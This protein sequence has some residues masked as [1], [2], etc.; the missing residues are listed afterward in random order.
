MKLAHWLGLVGLAFFLGLIAVLMQRR[1]LDFQN[2]DEAAAKAK[3]VGFFVMSDR[4]D[5]IIE[6]GFLVTPDPAN[7]TDANNLFKIGKMGPEWN[8]KVWV[9]RTSR[10]SNLV[11]ISDGAVLHYW[12]NVVAFGDSQM[13]DELEA[14]LRCN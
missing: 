12:G 14:K 3:E 5:G 7:T 6:V 1:P 8:K 4:A 13:L 9:T 11:A 10:L 2:L